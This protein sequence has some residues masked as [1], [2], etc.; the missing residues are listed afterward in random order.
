MLEEDLVITEKKTEL[1]KSSWYENKWL[2]LGYGATLSYAVITIINKVGNI[3]D[4]FK[5][6]L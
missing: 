4:L 2:Y 5:Q 6:F 1:V 3:T